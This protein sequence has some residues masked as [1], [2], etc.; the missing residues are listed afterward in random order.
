MEMLADINML[1]NS[2]TLY[3]K[4]SYDSQFGFFRQ[5]GSFANTNEFVWSNVFAV[6]CQTW[7]MSAISPLLIDQW[8]GFGASLN[9]WKTTKRI[10][11][12]KY[13]NETGLCEGLGFTDN[14]DDQVFSGEWTLGAS[15]MLRIF[16]RLYNDP[17]LKVE[18]DLLL[19]NV[20]NQL[21]QTD[22]I[23]GVDVKGIVYANRRYW[24]PFGWWANKVLSTAS[25]GWTVL[26]ESNYN[27]LHLG[28]EYIVDY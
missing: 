25:T 7:V 15:N 16:S 10:G 24:I 18:A 27:P 2:I 28:G 14:K 13:Q 19:N 22:T 8:F 4:D 21:T 9:I 26:L 11:G 17:S 6:D 5:G 3:V 12:Y 1:I 23:D 20:V